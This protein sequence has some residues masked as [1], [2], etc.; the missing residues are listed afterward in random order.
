MKKIQQLE[1]KPAAP[2]EL[3]DKAF[4]KPVF[5]STLTGPSDLNEGQHAHLECRVIPVGMQKNIAY[6]KQ[7]LTFF[8]I[9]F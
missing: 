1:E 8:K 4:D 3:E 9:C 6:S 7:I 5:I 2:T